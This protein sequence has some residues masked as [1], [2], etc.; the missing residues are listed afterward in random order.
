[1]LSN[2]EI[3]F[4]KL[5]TSIIWQEVDSTVASHDNASVAQCENNAITKYEVHCTAYRV[6]CTSG[7]GYW[8][9]F[10]LIVKYVINV[11]LLPYFYNFAIYF[12]SYDVIATTISYLDNRQFRR[13][14]QAEKL[15]IVTYINKV[16]LCVSM[17][18]LS[19]RGACAVDEYHGGVARRRYSQAR[20]SCSGGSAGCAGSGGGRRANCS[21]P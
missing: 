14:N 7:T 4:Y 19:S 8:L 11:N 12:L 5:V 10:D 2:N 9:Y 16:G 20:V 17:S 21:Q 13:V 1:M 18:M 15:T 6:Y 3:E